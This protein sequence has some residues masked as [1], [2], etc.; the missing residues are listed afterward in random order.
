[1]KNKGNLV[2]SIS[3]QW[4]CYALSLHNLEINDSALILFY[5]L[6]TGTDW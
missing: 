4:K 1:M 2:Y 6:A 3:S 5:F